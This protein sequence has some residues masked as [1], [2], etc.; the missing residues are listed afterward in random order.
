[1]M[2]D[3][4][5]QRAMKAAR[6]DEI[7]NVVETM[8]NLWLMAEAYRSGDDA[9]SFMEYFKVVMENMASTLRREGYPDLS[10]RMRIRHCPICKFSKPE[11]RKI[12]IGVNS[13]CAVCGAGV[14]GF[15]K[16]MEVTP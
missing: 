8:R 15:E 2:N 5:I 12:T 3:D 6:L 9:T 10:P 4:E 14:D 1:M 11:K 7:H 16:T 13:W